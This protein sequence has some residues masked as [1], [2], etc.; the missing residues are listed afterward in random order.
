VEAARAPAADPA[1]KDVH[2]ALAQCIA[3]LEEA[4]PKFFPKAG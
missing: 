1:F 3:L 4:A 2:T